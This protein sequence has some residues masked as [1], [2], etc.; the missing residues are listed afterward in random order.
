M[1]EDLQRQ[2]QGLGALIELE[3]KI[4]NARNI[5]E[6]GFLIVNATHD[7]IPYRQAVLWR[8]G[9]RREVAY[10]SGLPGIDKNTPFVA[11]MKRALAQISKSDP[12]EMVDVGPSQ[13]TGN[14]A[15]SWSEWLPEF[16]VW[17]PLK[18]QG[19][20]TIGG[21][22]LARDEAWNAVER[23]FLD[24][25]ADVFGHSCG[26]YW[27]RRGTF[28]K[29]LGALG[30]IRVT[31][32]VT[33]LIVGAMF[34]PV[35]QSVLAPGEVTPLKPTVVR[36]PLD[37]VVDK[38][39]V[40][41]N[42]TVEKGQTLFNLDTREL[43]NKLEVTRKEFSLVEAEYRQTAQ[44]AVLDRDAKARLSLLKR[45]MDAKA[46]EA[47]YVGSLLL[48]AHVP[49]P[50][51]GVAVFADVNDW[52]GRPVSIGEKIMT[53]ADPS[54]SELKIRL[55]VSDAINLEPGAE[56]VLFRNIDPNNPV[57]AKLRYASYEADVTPEGVL[58]YT[59]KADFSPGSPTPRIG[60][61]GTAKIYGQEVTVFYLLMR[62]PLATLR[63]MLGF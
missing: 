25:L 45:R 63:Q 60:L 10:V 19:G 59:I 37:G 16:A 39:H 44:R 5:D 35:R 61:R 56:I 32:L 47:K 48:R 3:A 36:S 7:L 50:S 42:Q 29:G 54:R 51:A 17:I 9:Q 2:V 22:F 14:V 34:I 12:G 27:E 4:R 26:Y 49:A 30:K 11:W 40:T 46:A 20:A 55:P 38:L 43:T 53:I 1:S 52:I 15:G 18:G 28:R 13:L 62:R 24:Y 23:R 8:G 6:L 31:L 21:L 41:P 33:A 58:A 57:P